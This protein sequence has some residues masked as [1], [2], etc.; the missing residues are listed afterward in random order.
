MKEVNSIYKFNSLTEFHR[1]FGLDKPL[2]PLISFIDIA[3]M[4]YNVGELPALIVMDFYK[5]AY[6]PGLCGNA[7]YGQN[8][9]DFGEGG[10]VFTSPNQVF[11]SPNGTSKSGCLLLVHPDF[12]LSYALANNIS[13]YGF[14]SYAV[15]EAL[16]LSNSERTTI[17]SV[18]KIISEELSS[19]ID[20]FSQ[21]VIVSQVGLLLNYCNRFYKRQFITRKA[22]H[23]DVLQKL[24]SILDDYFKNEQSL[25]QGL[26]TVQFL[27]EQ[28]NISA[29]YLGDMMRSL[30][31]Q[32]A[33][34][35]IHHKLI[36]KAKEILST[37]NLT[38]AEVA[39]QLGF[40]HPQSFSRLFKTKTN[41]SPLAFRHMFN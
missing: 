40:E 17:M 3:D 10:L 20:D 39:Y 16:H 25:K 7:K 27:S 41:L 14:F 35:H 23:V 34:Q 26:P 28:L 15:N 32:N 12:F 18:F 24:E 11:E 21:D 37:S 22:A 6:K 36:E 13:H 4:K 5:L 1:V 38:V 29:S 31:G 9:Y 33:Q 19:R 30:T 8:Y 2:H